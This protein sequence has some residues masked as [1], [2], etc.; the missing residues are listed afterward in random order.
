MDTG[1]S[2]YWGGAPA[3]IAFRRVARIFIEPDEEFGRQIARGEP[4]RV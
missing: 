3:P 2:S 4:L 1:V